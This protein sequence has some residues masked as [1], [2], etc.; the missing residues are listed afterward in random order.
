MISVEISFLKIRGLCL[1]KIFS[2]QDD[3][4]L[5]D[6]EDTRPEMNNLGFLQTQQQLGQ[7]PISGW[8]E[9]DF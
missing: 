2:V 6:F 4:D 7:K 9:A 1:A 8:N 5:S 3:V